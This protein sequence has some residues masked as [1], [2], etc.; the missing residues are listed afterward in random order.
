MFSIYYTVSSLYMY[1]SSC[2]FFHTDR[3]NYQIKCLHFP[4]LGCQGWQAYIENNRDGNSLWPGDKNDRITYK[5]KSPGRVRV[6]F[7]AV[8]CSLCRPK[9]MASGLVHLTRSRGP[10]S[11][12]GWG[13]CVMFLGNTLNSHSASL[14]PGVQMDTDKFNASGNPAMDYM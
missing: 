8:N 13:H 2:V 9:A 12:P 4:H 1:I 5:G 7:I 10:G 6:I 3:S 11:S 14:H